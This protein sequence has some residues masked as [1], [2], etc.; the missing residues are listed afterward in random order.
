VAVTAA[1][2]AA[3][4]WGLGRLGADPSY[5]VA[6]GRAAALTL[7]AVVTFVLMARALRVRE[8]TEVMELLT[9]RL[10]TRDRS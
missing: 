2:T 9:R 8:V 6:L 10:P 3:A 1:A 7:V 4:W 5:A